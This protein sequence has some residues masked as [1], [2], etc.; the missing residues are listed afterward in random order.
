MLLAHHYVP[1]AFLVLVVVAELTVA[2]AVG[3][4]RSALFPQQLQGDV[5]VFLKL[6]V[7]VR[8]VRKVADRGTRWLLIGGE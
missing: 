5:L 2:L 1:L 8:K 4:R 3:M 7:D 6:F